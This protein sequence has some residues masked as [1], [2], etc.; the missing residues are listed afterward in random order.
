MLRR[1]LVGLLLVGL[2]V[3]FQRQWIRFDLP[4]LAND[5]RM[6]FLAD[7]DPMRRLPILF[8]DL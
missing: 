4:R 8:K 5:L 1:L 7:P 2:G 6:P 3:G